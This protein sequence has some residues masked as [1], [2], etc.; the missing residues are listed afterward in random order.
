[1]LCRRRFLGALALLMGGLLA[2]CKHRPQDQPYGAQ[3]PTREDRGGDR[4]GDGGGY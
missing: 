4:G 3:R 1:M 2:G